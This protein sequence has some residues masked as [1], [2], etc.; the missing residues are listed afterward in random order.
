VGSLTFH[1]PIG[2]QGLL[3]DSFT[4]LTYTQVAGLLGR[5]ISPS[6]G[7]YLHTGQHKQNK[8]T[9]TSIP[10]A[11]FEPM[12]PAFERA[13]TIHTLDLAAIVIREL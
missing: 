5:G 9:Q 1:N 3:R 7:F 12:T 8:V 13:K 6:Q 10:R 11:G 2:L 4:L